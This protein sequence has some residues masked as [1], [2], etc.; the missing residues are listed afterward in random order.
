[1]SVVER[2]LSKL[3]GEGGGRSST[4]VV[5]RVNAEVTSEAASSEGSFHKWAQKFTKNVEFDLNALREA[6]LYAVGDQKLADQYRSIKQPI[7][8][9]LTGKPTP[10]QTGKNLVLIASALAGEGKTF[11][12]VNLSLSLASEQDWE[13]LLVDV[14][15]YNPKLTQLL[16][17]EDEP[18]FLDLLSD[19]S[20]SIS[21]VI[22]GTNIDGLAVI[23]LGGSRLNSAEL[24]ASQRMKDISAKLADTSNRRVIVFD[25]SPILLTPDTPILATQVGQVAMVVR[26]NKTL[27]YAVGEALEK[28]D[29]TKTIGLILNQGDADGSTFRYGDY[30]SYGRS[31]D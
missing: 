31:A 12:S 4:P 3:K 22:M 20:M 10:G 7:L 8:R 21:S 23:P 6:G 30:G 28:L 2:A 9:H 19:A 16:G 14:D 13:V 5:A 17:A 1:M 18:G 24:F 27:R 25:S 29:H 15:R 11:T 26:A